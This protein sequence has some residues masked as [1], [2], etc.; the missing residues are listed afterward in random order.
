MVHTAL[1]PVHGYFT[2]RLKANKNA[3]SYMDKII[4]QR[5][6]GS[7]M[8]VVKP[9]IEGEWFTG[10]FRDFGNFQLLYEILSN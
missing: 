8:T 10:K 6:W 2:I 9:K 5:T 7:K 1:V 4:I 3:G